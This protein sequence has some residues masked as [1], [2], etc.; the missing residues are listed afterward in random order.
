M[1]TADWVFV[2][3]LAVMV[4]ATFIACKGWTTIERIP[5]PA[6]DDPHDSNA[7][8]WQRRFDRFKEHAD[9]ALGIV[10]NDSRPEPPPDCDF[11]PD[12]RWKR[13]I[14]PDSP[15]YNALAEF[16]NNLHPSLRRPL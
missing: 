5:W 8:Y 6:A 3:V 11:D 15:D 13:L 12:E 1:S 10:A 16:A 4:I 7:P 2:S 9:R 14:D